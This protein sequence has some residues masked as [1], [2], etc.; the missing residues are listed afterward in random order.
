MCWLLISFLGTQ[1]DRK[2]PS[3]LIR[4]VCVGY[5]VSSTSLFQIW[6]ISVFNCQPVLIL[7]T[8]LTTE[9]L[10][11]YLNTKLEN[12]SRR[13][14]PSPIDPSATSHYTEYGSKNR[15]C[16]SSRVTSRL[17]GQFVFSQGWPLETALTVG[18][19]SG[20]QYAGKRRVVK[21][22]FVW[23]P[24]SLIFCWRWDCSFNQAGLRKALSRLPGDDVSS[25]G[26]A[27]PWCNCNS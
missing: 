26:W 20:I 3:K 15:L 27:C 13:K 19:T 10:Y 14:Y 12:D 18:L 16:E 2:N 5:T 25:L 9:I 22:C 1:R 24:L 21:S 8:N 6:F 11:W 7:I 23:S 17:S 4:Q